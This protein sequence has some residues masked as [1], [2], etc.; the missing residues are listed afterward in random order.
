[1]LYF[2]DDKQQ[3]TELLATM[4]AYKKVIMNKNP[5]IEDLFVRV[6]F[7]PQLRKHWSEIT[8]AAQRKLESSRIRKAQP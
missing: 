6:R 1:V 8:A 2:V 5:S 7:Q 4:D 3:A